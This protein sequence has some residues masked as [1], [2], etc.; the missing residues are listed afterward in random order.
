[1]GAERVI[2]DPVD[3]PA[4]LFAQRRIAELRLD[5]LQPIVQSGPHRHVVGPHHADGLGLP[6]RHR[7]KVADMQIELR[8]RTVG[9][10][11]IERDRHQN[12][13]DALCHAG[14]LG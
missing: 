13:D 9:V 3:K 11:V 7:D 14:R 5:I 10:G 8:R 6:E 1:M 12:V 2:R 4:Q